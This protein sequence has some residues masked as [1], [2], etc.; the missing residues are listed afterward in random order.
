MNQPNHIAT[1]VYF[2][3]VC[4]TLFWD[5]TTLGLIF[6]HL[7]RRKYRA[8]ELLLKSLSSD[9]SPLRL[10]LTILEKL[11]G[12]HIL[13]HLAFLMLR[14]ETSLEVQISASEYASHLLK[15]RAIHETFE[16]LYASLEQ[17]DTVILASASV[18]PVITALGEK[19]GLATVSSELAC[20]RGRLT[21]RLSRDLSG[22][23]IEAISDKFGET[24]FEG[25]TQAISDNL[26]DQALLARCK[27]C[28]VILHKQAHKHRW[29]VKNA[30]FLTPRPGEIRA[31]TKES[32]L[33][34]DCARTS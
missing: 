20:H 14:G 29:R 23:K 27:A 4:G 16:I 25:D 2:F 8:R 30:T 7:N 33:S 32:Q 24:I 15:F 12:Q 19:L 28:T 11:T 17:D 13:K 31:A 18:D 3:D 1:R 34:L 5:D 21:G 10:L 26:S 6:W 22:R 9:R